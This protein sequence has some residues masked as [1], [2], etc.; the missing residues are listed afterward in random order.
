MNPGFVKMRRA[1]LDHI[2]ES[3]LTWTEAHIYMDV[4]LLADPAS[5]IWHGCAGWLAAMFDLRPRTCR[6]SIER[7]ESKGY[8]KRFTTPGSHSNY[9]ILINKYLCTQGAAKDK[10]LNAVETIDWRKPIYEA[11][12]EDVQEHGKEDVKDVAGDTKK[13]REVRKRKRKTLNLT[14]SAE[15][16]L[17]WAAY[18][19]KIKKQESLDAWNREVNG[20][21]AL[22]MAAI[23]RLKPC[24]RWQEGFIPN[25]TT[26]LNQHRWTDE[27]DPPTPDELKRAETRRMLSEAYDGK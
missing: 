26:F 17:F 4:I 23:E 7:L 3:R 27:P 8:I 12:K 22:V 15:F 5:G 21:S 11:R 2:T 10:R 20:N 19:S 24:R 1:I 18:P 9:P 16:D 6:D 25:P 13:E 14:P